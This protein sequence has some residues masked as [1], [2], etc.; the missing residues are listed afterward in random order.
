MRAR[1]ANAY[2]EQIENGNGHAKLQ[3]IHQRSG[4]DTREPGRTQQS[5]ARR[6]LYLR[7]GCQSLPRH[8]I[9]T[10]LLLVIKRTEKRL[11]V[12]THYPA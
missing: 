5:P 4:N 3:Y 8:A 9:I 12:W 7:A 10:E 11:H 1:R 2:L 6:I